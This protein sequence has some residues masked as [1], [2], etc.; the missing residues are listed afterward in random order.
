MCPGAAACGGART[1]RIAAGD[2]AQAAFAAL[3]LTL[4]CGGAPDARPSFLLL[5]AGTQDASELPCYSAAAPADASARGACRVARNGAL[6]VWAFSETPA[7]AAAAA[8]LLSS[9]PASVHG[10]G[11][12]AARFLATG[13]P[14][15]A[16]ELSRAGYAT[17]AFVGDAAL[18]RARNLHAGF[19]H[20]EVAADDTGAV[21]SG[22]L[23]WLDARRGQTGPWLLW[24]HLP[25]AD[26]PRAAASREEAIDALLDGVDTSARS[27]TDGGAADRAAPGAGVVFTALR[28]SRPRPGSTPLALARVR[29]PLLWRA[30]GPHRPAR[31]IVAPVG[32]LDVTPTLLQA[33]GARALERFAGEAL[34]PGALPPGTPHPARPIDL[35][36]PGRRWLGVV[37]ARRYYARR[38]HARFARTA[39]LSD[40]GSL[41]PSVRVPIGDPEVAPLEARLRERLAAERAGPQS[42]PK[43]ESFRSEG[44]IFPS[45]PGRAQPATGT[46]LGED[47]KSPE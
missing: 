16:T 8:T 37:R 35:E 14:T 34:H 25:D 28:G 27:S 39:L 30:P 38:R 4:A 31:R 36:G 46:S 24:V 2:A 3:L 33:A 12:S 5:T 18:N 9:E 32:L 23:A 19:A 1:R 7:V 45:T 26:G 15:L 21:A 29:V 40:D 44:S 10:V 17:A 11:D 22:A 42:R 6:F 47:P 13:R 41:P 20:Y 43:E